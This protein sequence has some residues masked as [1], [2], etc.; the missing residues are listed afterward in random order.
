M[1]AARM[2]AIENHH[3]GVAEE[4]AFGALAR[5]ERRRHCAEM[6]LVGE[7][8]EMLAANTC[9]IN[10]FRFRKELLA[11]PNSNHGMPP[12]VPQFHA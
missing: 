11:G 4:P 3:I 9:K 5:D 7:P 6:F 1:I 8:P 2:E 10:D 12:S